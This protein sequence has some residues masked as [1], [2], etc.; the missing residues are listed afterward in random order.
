M[1]KIIGTPRRYAVN[2]TER[3]VIVSGS[4]NLLVKALSRDAS[5]LR[6]VVDATEQSLFRSPVPHAWAQPPTSSLPRIEELT[7]EF[8]GA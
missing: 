5:R 1:N 2:D 8:V 4:F 7:Q 3:N 6:F